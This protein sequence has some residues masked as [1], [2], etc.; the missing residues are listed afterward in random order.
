MNIFKWN[1]KE[2][3]EEEAPPVVDR[4]K[5]IDELKGKIQT[6]EGSYAESQVEVRKLSNELADIH[7]AKALVASLKVIR[8]YLVKDTLDQAAIERYSHESLQQN[9]LSALQR[10]LGDMYPPSIRGIF[11]GLR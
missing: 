3:K 7:Q 8:E 6:L 1:G 5:E 10:P 4:Q 11:G 2:M 9:Q